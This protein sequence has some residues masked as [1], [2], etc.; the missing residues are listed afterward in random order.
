M[1]DYSHRNT[2]FSDDETSGEEKQT[3]DDEEEESD[4]E[5]K[6]HEKKEDIKK[7]NERAEKQ[8]TNIIQPLSQENK[9]TKEGTEVVGP[10]EDSEEKNTTCPLTEKKPQHQS[11]TREEK[12]KRLFG[13]NSRISLFKWR[14]ST[15]EKQEKDKEEASVV[16]DAAEKP[17]SLDSEDLDNSNSIKATGLQP[18]RSHSATCTLL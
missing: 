3:D 4:Q 14:S 15:K 12:P 8:D 7:L 1:Q 2:E 11:E 5:A 9:D 17:S 16:S 10:I 6:Q 13:S 18:L